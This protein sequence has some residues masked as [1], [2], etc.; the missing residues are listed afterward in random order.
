M[1]QVVAYFSKKLRPVERRY[2]ATDREALAIV[3]ACRQFNSYLWGTRFTIRTDHQPVVSLFKHRTKSPRMN[4]W[5][6]EMKDYQYQIEYKQ[7]RKNV[8]ADHLSRPVRVIQNNEEQW[9]GKSKE[10]VIEMQGR[11]RRWNE[12]AEYLRGGRVPRSRFP[13]ATIDQFT[14]EDDVLYLTKQ[15]IDGPRI[16]ESGHALHL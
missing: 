9:L 15:K 10:E 14:L 13:R 7:G 8:V 4:R 3:L 12:V 11:E 2:S 1:P 6:L 5:I 16:K